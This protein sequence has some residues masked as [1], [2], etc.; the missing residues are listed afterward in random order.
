VDRFI[1]AKM[2]ASGRTGSDSI[3][4]WIGIGASSEVSLNALD[5]GK[6][7]MVYLTVLSTSAG[8]E[9]RSGRQRDSVRGVIALLPMVVAAAGKSSSHVGDL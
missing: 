2:M 8:P 3:N 1:K 6:G 9:L 5:A 7:S 4:G